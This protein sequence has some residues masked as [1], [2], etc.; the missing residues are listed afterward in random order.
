MA[1]V[2]TFL[3]PNTIIKTA[4]VTVRMLQDTDNAEKTGDIPLYFTRIGAMGYVTLKANY[5]QTG[6]L[7]ATTNYFKVLAG[8][9]PADFRPAFSSQALF[10]VGHGAGNNT[11]NQC[12]ITFATDGSF[13]IAAGTGADRPGMGVQT[14]NIFPQQTCAY[15]LA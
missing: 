2:N 13:T 8:T 12:E 7:T 11:N 5:A 9:V 6:D 15:A 10:I 14:I 3:N 4:T 1:T